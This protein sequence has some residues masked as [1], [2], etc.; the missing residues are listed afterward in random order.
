MQTQNFRQNDQVKKIHT[1]YD[2]PAT[3]KYV[4]FKKE[5]DTFVSE[6]VKG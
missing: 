1:G 2:G 6:L 3:S 5:F 4:S